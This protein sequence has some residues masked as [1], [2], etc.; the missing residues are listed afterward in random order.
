MQVWLR[1]FLD[2][3]EVLAVHSHTATLQVPKVLGPT[4]SR[5]GKVGTRPGGVPSLTYLPYLPSDTQSPREFRSIRFGLE[6]HSRESAWVISSKGYSESCV[7]PKS[8][9]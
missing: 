1:A 8:L 3:T 6:N 2:L 5:S 4:N 9:C 7:K